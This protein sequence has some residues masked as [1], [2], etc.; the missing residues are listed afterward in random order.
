[1]S[2]NTSCTV[3]MTD[4][5]KILSGKKPPE[6]QTNFKMIELHTK[7]HWTKRNDIGLVYEVTVVVVQ[8]NVKKNGLWC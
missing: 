8:Y 6:C 1:M 5:T 7:D 2:H 3:T 4:H